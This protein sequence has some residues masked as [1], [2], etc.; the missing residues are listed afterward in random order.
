MTEQLLLRKF[1]S[2]NQTLV[3][4]FISNFNEDFE[5][6]N[7][8]GKNG[9]DALADALRVNGS[10]K[11]LHLRNN[12]ITDEGLK[13]LAEA[14]LE[15]TALKILCVKYPGDGLASLDQDTR[16]ILEERITCDCD[17]TDT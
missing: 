4:F 6:I 8:V 1:Y 10:L 17:C 13:H 16:E 2:N 3:N 5:W 11:E 7:K 9:A 14:L 15:N 12:D